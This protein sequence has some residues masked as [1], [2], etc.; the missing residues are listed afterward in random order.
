MSAPPPLSDSPPLEPLTAPLVLQPLSLL[1][2]EGHLF[3]N[4]L[5]GAL[6]HSSRIIVDL[7]WIEDLTQDLLSPFVNVILQ[8][9]QQGKTITLLS[10]THEVRTMVDRLIQQRSHRPTEQSYGVFTPDFEAFLEQ[11]YRPD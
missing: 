10:M 1:D 8:A 11:H 3:L 4:H 2:Q 9:Q 7:L 5:E 6:T